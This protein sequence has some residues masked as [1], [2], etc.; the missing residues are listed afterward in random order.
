MHGASKFARGYHIIRG[1][2]HPSAANSTR[3]KR[4]GSAPLSLAHFL[5]LGIY[6]FYLSLTFAGGVFWTFSF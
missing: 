3:F 5:N 1:I 6:L 2:S 4:D